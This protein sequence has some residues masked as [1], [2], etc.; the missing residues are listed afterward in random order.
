MNLSHSASSVSLHNAFAELRQAQMADGPS[1]APPIFNQTGPPFPTSLTNIVGSFSGGLSGLPPSSTAAPSS[2]QSG[3]AQLL[4]EGVVTPS[5]TGVPAHS[6]MPSTV[7]TIT[8]VSTQPLTTG[9]ISGV[10]VSTCVPSA[11]TS[12]PTLP[13]VGGMPVAPGTVTS[14]PTQ[15]LPPASTAAVV[16]QTLTSPPLQLPVGNVACTLP[17]TSVSAPVMST[18][19]P[20]QIQLSSSTSTPSFVESVTSSAAHQDVMKKP[21]EVTAAISTMGMS[22]PISAPLTYAGVAASGIAAVADS[23]PIIHPTH[24]PT[25]IATTPIISQTGGTVSTPLAS[26]VPISGAVP[27]NHQIPTVQHT[28]QHGQT[29]PSTAPCL[30]HTHSIEG[31]DSLTKSGIDDIKTLEEKL[32]S[33]FSEHGSVGTQHSLTPQEAPIGQEGVPLPGPPSTTISTQTKPTST[34]PPTSLPLG[35]SGMSVLGQGV[36]PGQAVTPVTYVS[37]AAASAAAATAAPGKA[38]T[39]PSKP[40]LSRVPV[41]CALTT[42]VK[43]HISITHTLAFITLVLSRYDPWLFHFFKLLL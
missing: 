16:P 41:S 33:L 19:T 22:L 39:P 10:S 30:P 2:L 37:A 28:L 14:P 40:P 15:S 1:T 25:A 26:Q 7:P 3:V 24:L 9:V 34:A 11:V 31:E 38:G 13:L 32:R 8:T 5:V 35:Q 20:A 27:V 36:T 4:V 12:L 29:L 6:T 23:A 43:L 42:Y 21:A 18:V 17:H